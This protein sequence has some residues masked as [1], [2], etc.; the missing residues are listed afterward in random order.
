VLEVGCGT[1]VVTAKIAGMPGVGEAVGV[2]PVP[3]FVDRGRVDLGAD[4]LV[5]AGTL[6]AATG[7]ALKSEA[8]QRVAAGT[9][10]GHIAYASLLAT[11]P[12]ALTDGP[13]A[14]R[15]PG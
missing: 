2:D 4:T 14:R 11:R 13:A 10:F 9:F 6:S 5:G 1:G 12:R 15:G 7:E 8:R 3:Y